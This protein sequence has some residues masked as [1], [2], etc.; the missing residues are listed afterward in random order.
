MILQSTAIVRATVTGASPVVAGKDI[1][2]SYQLQVT[3]ALKSPAG[4]TIKAGQ[5]LQAAVPGGAA[6]GVRQTVAGAPA[7]S[8]GQDCVLFLWTSRSGITQIIGLSQ[9]LFSVILDANGN[10]QLVR[11]ASQALVLTSSGQPAANVPVSMSLS[12]LRSEIQSVLG[13]SK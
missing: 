11:P 4:L 6:R 12:A 5:Q 13:A 10:P 2:T 8:A 1:Y 9:G 7:L 3:E